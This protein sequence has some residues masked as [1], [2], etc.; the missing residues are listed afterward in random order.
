MRVQIVEV[1]HH[2]RVNFFR[3]IAEFVIVGVVCV[4]IVFGV[5]L[6]A[7]WMT[8][9]RHVSTFWRVCWSYFTFLPR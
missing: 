5:W 4:L 7:M 6:G 8:A 9:L 1:C 3:A 2:P